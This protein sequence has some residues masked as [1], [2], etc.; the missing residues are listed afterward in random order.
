[1]SNYELVYHEELPADDTTLEYASIPQDGT[2]LLLICRIRTNRAATNDAVILKANDTTLVTRRFYFGNGSYSGDASTGLAL[3]LSDTATAG[4]YSQIEFYIQRYTGTDRKKRLFAFGA[5]DGAGDQTVGYHSL[6]GAK[7]DVAGTAIT[8]LGI[9]PETGTGFKAGSS[10][11][12]YK[13]TAGSD[14]VTTVS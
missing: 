2:D 7:Y 11:S 10:F 5:V 1:M 6:A 14:G 13:I 8:K 9:V 3:S 4:A 12:L